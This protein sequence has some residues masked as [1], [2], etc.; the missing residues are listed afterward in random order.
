[1][2]RLGWSSIVGTD[3]SSANTSCTPPCLGDLRV[4][5]LS[6]VDPRAHGDGVDDVH[7]EVG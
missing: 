1:M 2:V 6:A 3:T 7:V 4:L 5:L